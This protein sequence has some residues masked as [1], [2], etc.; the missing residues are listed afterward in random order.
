MPANK[1]LLSSSPHFFSAAT[2]RKIMLAVIIALVP[3]TIYGVYLFGFSALLVVLASVLGAVGSEWLF[4]LATKQESH[5]SDCSAVVT[6]LLLAL[7]L[8]PSIPVWMAFMG[9]AVSVVVAKEFFGGLGMNP[10]NP[11][12]I[13]RAFLLM[14][15]PAPMT[16]WHRP[17]Q[18]LVDAAS[19]ATPLN[20]LKTGGSL[21]DVASSVGASNAGGLYWQLFLG[22]RSGSL[23]E[24]SILLVTLG[25][26]FLIATGVIQFVV[27]LAMLASTA[28]FSLA[29]GMD[30]LFSLLSGGVVFGAFFMATDYATSPLTVKGKIL[31]GAGIGLVIVL[32]RRFGGFPEGVTYAI[33]IMNMLTPFLDRLR[34]KKYGYVKPRKPAPPKDG[35]LSKAGVS[36]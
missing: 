2:T 35:S 1:L 31:Y 32:I 11:A 6:G 22:N 34:T 7:I 27:P 17:L 19:G 12:L 20:I 9:A 25:G 23:G 16:T 30:P 26:L 21:A 3:S 5:L 8:P 33:L 14:S 10:F 18:G 28:L 13:G 29:V 15:F 4:R 36:K 24:T